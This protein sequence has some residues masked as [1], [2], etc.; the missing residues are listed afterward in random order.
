MR[1]LCFGLLLL[2]LTTAYAQDRPIYDHEHPYKSTQAPKQPDV[3][4]EQVI[5]F[6][7]EEPGW[8]TEVELRNNLTTRDLTVTRHSALPTVASTRCHP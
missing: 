5:T 3:A 1:T 4:N 8:H 7:T 2:T 6:W